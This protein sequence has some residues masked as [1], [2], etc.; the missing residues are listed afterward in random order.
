MTGAEM[1]QPCENQGLEASFQIPRIATIHSGLS[2]SSGLGIAPMVRST[3]ILYQCVV[4]GSAFSIP[5]APTISAPVQPTQATGLRSMSAGYVAPATS[6]PMTS[7][8]GS[9]HREPEQRGFPSGGARAIS[10]QA[11]AFWIQRR[12]SKPS[13]STASFMAA[14]ANRRGS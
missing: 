11:C 4:A 1:L 6:S 8:S 10:R 9:P 12:R 3:P 5:A 7:V 14:S 2:R 13:A